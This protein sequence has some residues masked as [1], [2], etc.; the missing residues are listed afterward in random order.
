MHGNV[1]NVFSCLSNT[2]ALNKSRITYGLSWD[3]AYVSVR[4]CVF[5]YYLWPSIF[6]NVCYLCCFSYLIFPF[7]HCLSF[8]LISFALCVA[9]AK[10]L[11]IR[12][13]ESKSDAT[14]K[15]SVED[16]GEKWTWFVHA[17]Q[18]N[19]SKNIFY[20]IKIRDISTWFIVPHRT[21][22]HNRILDV[23]AKTRFSPILPT[24]VMICNHAYSRTYWDC[25]CLGGN[26]VCVC[27]RALRSFPLLHVQ[28][29][30]SNTCMARINGNCNQ[31]RRMPTIANNQKHK[32][33]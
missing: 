16:G 23:P 27:E 11:R 1:F 7:V 9:G 21:Y 32:A 30:L 12:G 13:R 14:G 18:F 28:F 6:E 17:L 4:A 29:H 20:V 19:D 5:A 8:I 15:K 22:T 33:M 26:Y 10:R 2:R 25:W 31:M 24:M 3:E